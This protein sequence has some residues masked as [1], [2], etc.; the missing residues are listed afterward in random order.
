MAVESKRAKISKI[1]LTSDAIEES[2]SE[3]ISQKLL[4][5]TALMAA[6]LGDES[7]AEIKTTEDD[8]NAF[9]VNQRY[10]NCMN[11]SVVMLDNCYCSV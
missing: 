11:V 4:H 9:A 6:P 8:I 7:T 10:N 5:E 1:D 2:Q 3:I